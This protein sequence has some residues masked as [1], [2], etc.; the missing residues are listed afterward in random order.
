[1]TCKPTGD[2][3]VE[4][5]G[6]STGNRKATYVD[7]ENPFTSLS[8]RLVLANAGT[9]GVVMTTMIFSATRV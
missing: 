1:V 4:L 6:F 2:G 8:P 7:K 9:A 5:T 3:G